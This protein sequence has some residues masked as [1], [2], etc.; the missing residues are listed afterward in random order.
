M[1]RGNTFL[2]NKPNAA[3]R[4]MPWSVAERRS[5]CMPLFGSY[6]HPLSHLLHWG[7]EERAADPPPL[8]SCYA[9]LRS[10]SSSAFL[11][12]GHQA[13]RP[14]TR[15]VVIPLF[16]GFWVGGPKLLSFGNTSSCPHLGATFVLGHGARA[17]TLK[18]QEA[19]LS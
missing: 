10:H 4:R 3:N 19:I 16:M 1:L 6:Q 12:G 14:A 17:S 13:G 7:C 11:V 2:F 9:L 5:A 18:P 8:P 15:P